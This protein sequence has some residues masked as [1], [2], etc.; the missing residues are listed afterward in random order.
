MR[1]AV[2]QGPEGSNSV[3]ENLAALESAVAKAAA[4]GAQLLITP[5]MSASGYNV[6][7][8][9]A[10][11]AESTDGPIE[12]RL[13]EAARQHGIALIY[14]YPEREGDALY[15]TAAVLGADG[16]EIARYRKTHL[17]GDFET[18]HFTP[19]DDLVVQ[20]DLNGIR[21]G[22]V[23]CYD[24]EFPEVVRA[25][26]GAGTQLLLVPTALMLPFDFVADSVVPVR[27]WE[28][29][30]CLVYADRCGTEGDLTYV[31]RSCVIG[32]DGTELARAGRGE[33]LLIADID[34]DTL[35]A[36]KKLNTY[37]RDRRT[38]LYGA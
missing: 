10:S 26:A 7:D 6:D 31:G 18:K 36:G 23:V 12:H 13:A 22:V 29:E 20:F 8:G 17:F 33:E 25:H 24:V 3:E 28:N 4:Q 9:Y 30:L 21:C 1:V 37:L 38:D 35:V 19:A 15:N 14:G 2:Y 16:T 34:E 11:S 27:A 32:S 5:E